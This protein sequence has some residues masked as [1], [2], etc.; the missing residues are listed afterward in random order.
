VDR[1]VSQFALFTLLIGSF[2]QVG[3][4]GRPLLAAKVATNAQSVDDEQG[5][6]TAKQGQDQVANLVHLGIDYARAGR[7]AAAES[8]YRKALR[9]DPHCV[10]AQ[11]NLGLAY[12]KANDFQDAIPPLDAAAHEGVDSDQVH[13]LLAMSMY[14]LH[15]Y[16]PASRHFEVLFKRQPTNTT[17]QY[18]LSE[19]YMRSHQTEQLP[20]FL[21]QL[22][23]VAPDSAVI[24]ML[25]GEQYDR[26]GQTEKAIPEFLQVEAG[27]PDM[28]LVHFALGYFYWEQNLLDKAAE[29][30]EGEVKLKNGEAAEAEGFLGDIA[31]RGGRQA[32]AEHL[33]RESLQI[34]P[35]VRIAH[36]DLGVICAEKKDTSAAVQHFRTAIALDTQRADAYYR[37]ATLYRQLGDL[38]RQRAL[39]AKVEQ[40]HAAEHTTVADMVSAHETR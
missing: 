11:I 2:F 26:L 1:L 29:Q 9:I 34:D 25:A 14:A 37:L 23:A 28:P 33:L 12:F 36:Y 39:L 16:E 8:A 30:F 18:L 7:Y 13:T 3:G 19:S 21:Q 5:G 31:L 17:L 10:A 15:R 32:E 6:A 20:G 4:V 24:H 22:Q 38:N 35:K 27:A 40:L